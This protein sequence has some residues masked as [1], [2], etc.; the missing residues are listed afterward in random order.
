MAA[1]INPVTVGQRKAF[2]MPTRDSDPPS[3]KKGSATEHP[4][5]AAIAH[6][7]AYSAGLRDDNLLI[8]IVISDPKSLHAQAQID[9]ATAENQLNPGQTLRFWLQLHFMIA[10][11]GATL[12]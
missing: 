4:K 5:R 3:W 7:N 8:F 11:T 9:T 10:V 6:S 12:Y 1:A 2:A